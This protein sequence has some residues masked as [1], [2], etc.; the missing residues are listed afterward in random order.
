MSSKYYVV[1]VTALVTDSA[2]S[3][4]RALLERECESFPSCWER[5]A[6]K[7][8]PRASG[9]AL[10]I[11]EI[12]FLVRNQ[13]PKVP[14]PICLDL[15]M[16][17]TA[18]CAGSLRSNNQIPLS[19]VTKRL[20]QQGECWERERRGLLFCPRAEGEPLLAA[21]P[22]TCPR[23][24]ASRASVI[25]HIPALFLLGVVGPPVTQDRVSWLE[26]ISSL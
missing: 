21:L 17:V 3:R 19:A 5:S 14:P 9:S 13:S 12:P 1:L 22:L 4:N 16:Q 10:V 7:P 15:I 20:L 24:V 23:P 11:R 25:H 6:L 2:G 18:G 8:E 26:V